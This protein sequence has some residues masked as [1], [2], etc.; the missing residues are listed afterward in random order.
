M[1]LGGIGRALYWTFK[2]IDVII[3][4]LGWRSFNVGSNLIVRRCRL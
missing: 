2:I 4:A 3:H 1:A